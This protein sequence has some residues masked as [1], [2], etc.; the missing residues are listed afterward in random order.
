MTFLYLW[1]LSNTILELRVGTEKSVR[2]AC[3]PSG[4]LKNE[5]RKV[6]H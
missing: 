6:E 5:G 3:T 2:M 4:A 1:I